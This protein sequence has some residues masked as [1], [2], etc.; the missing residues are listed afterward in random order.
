M[1]GHPARPRSVRHQL[2]KLISYRNTISI[3]KQIPFASL[4]DATPSVVFNEPSLMAL[5]LP[6]LKSRPKKRPK[7]QILA[8]RLRITTY[9]AVNTKMTKYSIR[10]SSS[11]NSVMK[12]YPF[13][14]ELVLQMNF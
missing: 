9:A 14:V 1:K 2:M 6:L 11:N 3:K 7:Y 10:E 5:R 8:S 13:R 4:I 12:Y